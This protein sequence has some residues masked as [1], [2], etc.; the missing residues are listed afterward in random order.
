MRKHLVWLIAFGIAAAAC[1]DAA[2]P[3]TG[4]ASVTVAPADAT[5]APAETSSP[6]AGSEAPGT[7][8]MPDSEPTDAPPT[9]PS[10]DGPPAEDFALA[11]ADGGTFQPSAEEKPI[12]LIF[13]AEW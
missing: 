2:S 6:P 11:L 3:D 12:Y 1:G 8:R 10:F 7:T 4:G 5:E 13:W 9:T